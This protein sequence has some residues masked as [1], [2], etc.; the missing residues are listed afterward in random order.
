MESPTALRKRVEVAQVHFHQLVEE[1]VSALGLAGQHHEE[2]VV[3]VEELAEFKQVAAEEADDRAVGLLPQPLRALAEQLRA[4]RAG[5]NGPRRGRD[6]G[7]HALRYGRL[8]VVDV[9]LF[10]ERPVGL[11][12]V[13][14]VL[15]HAGDDAPTYL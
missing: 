15:R 13:P 14:D 10:E 12:E 9:V 1:A 5:G 4:V 2:V 6:G 8:D 11:L 7:P 3:A